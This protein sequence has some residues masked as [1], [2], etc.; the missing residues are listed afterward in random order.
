MKR[1]Q[2]VPLH[3]LARPDGTDWERNA[4]QKAAGKAIRAAGLSGPVWH[5]LRATSASWAA[6]GQATEKQLQAMLG[7]LTPAMSQHYARNAEQ[8]HLARDAI[9]AIAVPVE[10][11]STTG[12]GKRRSRR[13]ANKVTG[14]S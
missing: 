12:S 4:F 11:T 1:R 10:S 13:V 7:H 8:R 6:D 14:H 5:G 2:L 3:I 9:E